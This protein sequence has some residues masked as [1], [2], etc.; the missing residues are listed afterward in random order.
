MFFASQIYEIIVV[1]RDISYLRNLKCSTLVY[2]NAKILF[3]MG[4]FLMFDC[5]KVFFCEKCDKNRRILYSPSSYSR[6]VVK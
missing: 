3:E 5:K 1:Y 6:I 4:C 2:K